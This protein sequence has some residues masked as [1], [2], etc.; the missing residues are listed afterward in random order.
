MQKLADISLR[1]P[2]FGSMIV[3]A[4]VVLGIS[5]YFR[6]GV[7]RFPSMDLP[8]VTVQTF[9]PGAAPEEI[10]TTVSQPIEE[11]VNTV[12]SITELRSSSNPGSSNVQITFD[13]NKDIEVA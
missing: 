3:L 12:D 13:L 6:L 9:L 8:T 10:E 4:L 5:S 2:V 7:D 11:A 1:R